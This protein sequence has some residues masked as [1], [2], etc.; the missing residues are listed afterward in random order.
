MAPRRHTLRQSERG[1]RRHLLAIGAE[2]GALTREAR[3]VRDRADG[4]EAVKVQRADLLDD[5]TG[6]VLHARHADVGQGISEELLG[7]RPDPCGSG[8]Q[9]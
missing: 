4:A 5:G 2:G 8:V 3:F 9:R 6:G 7:P 1:Q